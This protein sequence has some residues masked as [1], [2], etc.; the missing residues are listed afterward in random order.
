MRVGK[1]KLSV[2]I[3]AFVDFCFSILSFDGVGGLLNWKIH[4][5]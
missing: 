5:Y 2:T 3:D 1:Q 4:I